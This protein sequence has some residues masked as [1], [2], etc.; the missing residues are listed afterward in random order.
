MAKSKLIRALVKATRKKP[1]V[2]KKVVK[3]SP[4][5]K[6]K[7]L[8]DKQATGLGIAYGGALLG[9]GLLAENRIEKRKLERSIKWTKEEM[10]KVKKGWY[11]TD[12]E[13]ERYREL[14]KKLKELERRRDG[15]KR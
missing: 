8:S 2:K 15:G 14:K 5:K 11:P 4:G 6:K 1:V 10:A 12:W 3:K 7:Q 13:L 9:G